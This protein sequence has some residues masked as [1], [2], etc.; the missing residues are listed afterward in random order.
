MRQSDGAWE[1]IL[2]TCGGRGWGKEEKK[3]RKNLRERGKLKKKGK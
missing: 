3:K 1:V 2:L